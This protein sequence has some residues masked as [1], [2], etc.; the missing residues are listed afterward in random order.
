MDRTPPASRRPAACPDPAH[1][2][3]PQPG[4]LPGRLGT[5]SVPANFASLEKGTASAGAPERSGVG[6]ALFRGVPPAQHRVGPPARG[7][8][9]L[10]GAAVLGDVKLKLNS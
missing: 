4:C 1:P 6:A 2:L 10:G 5:A 3:P 7:H 8:G 9:H